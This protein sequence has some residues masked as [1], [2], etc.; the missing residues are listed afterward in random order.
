MNRKAAIIS[1]RGP[2]LTNSEILLLKKEKP[3]GV[4]LFKRNI[5]SFKQTIM[6]TRKIRKCMNDSLYPIMIDEEG[7]KV[8]RLSKLF[9]TKEFSQY[10]F[11]KLYEKNKAKGKLIY[12]YYLETICNILV[13]L[14]I[15]INT[16]PVMDLLQKNTHEIIKDRVYSSKHNTV[17]SLGKFC[18]SFLKKKKIAPVVKHV[19]G[20]GC[21]NVDSHYRLPKV[22][23]K[24]NK[25]YTD[26]FRL[27]KNLNSNFMMT[28]H[29]L[30]KKVDPKNLTTFSSHIIKN[31]IRKKLNFKGI[32]ISDDISMKAL[33]KNLSNNAEKALKAGCN[34]VLYCRGDI[35]ESRKLLKNLRPIDNF[36]LKKTYQFYDFLR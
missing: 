30:Y 1:I 12:K 21:A 8:S 5:V 13:D 35:K 2:N 36:T 33:S 7:G 14:G 11:G 4:I 23:K 29:I 22:L 6:L 9:S 34:L 28:A 15:N 18:I 25:L 26:D 10:F 16:I 24:L 17:K 19:P 27:F 20:H 3:W 31:V 32:L